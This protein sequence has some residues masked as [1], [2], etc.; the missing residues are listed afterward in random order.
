[1]FGF[2]ALNVTVVLI[3]SYFQT[4]GQSMSSS[5]CKNLELWGRLMS[6]GEISGEFTIQSGDMR[7][8]SVSFD[9]CH[10]ERFAVT[11]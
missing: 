4:L 2:I 9:D 7:K 10:Q 3:W 6:S 8:A 11:F 1:M 5:C